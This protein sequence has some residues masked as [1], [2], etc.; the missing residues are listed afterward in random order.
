[1]VQKVSGNQDKIS[2]P[3]PG[4]WQRLHDDTPIAFTTHILSHS[5]PYVLCSD[6]EPM[7]LHVP[8]ILHDL[9]EPISHPLWAAWFC[10]SLWPSRD[11]LGA[12]LAN[13]I[14]RLVHSHVFALAPW[15]WPRELAQAVHW[16]TGDPAQGAQ[17][18][19]LIS[20][21]PAKPQP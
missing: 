9:A 2:S 17:L 3:L 12:M 10:D 13:S 8:M 15:P 6:L 14:W 7:I 19:Q 20:K 1:M 5:Y 11:V 21:Q 18:P 16:R 4:L